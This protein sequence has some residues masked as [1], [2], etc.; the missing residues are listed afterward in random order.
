M[1]VGFA[2]VTVHWYVAGSLIS[3][4]TNDVDVQ[5]Y[6]SIF[7]LAGVSFR[8]KFPLDVHVIFALIGLKLLS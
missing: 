6:V 7:V 3:T 8:K 2:N 4:V 1:L 5:V